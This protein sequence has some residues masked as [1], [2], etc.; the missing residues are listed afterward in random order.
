[1]CVSRYHNS[2]FM[3]KYSN[4]FM[5]F[6]FPLRSETQNV[7]GNWI[8]DSEVKWLIYEMDNLLTK[9][10]F[11]HV[12]FLHPQLISATAAVNTFSEIPSPLCSASFLELHQCCRN[13]LGLPASPTHKCRAKAP[14]GNTQSILDGS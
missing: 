10:W 3:F 5:E 8:V 14:R 2:K 13:L 4:W 1:M 7:Q 11:S 6:I 9:V 12:T